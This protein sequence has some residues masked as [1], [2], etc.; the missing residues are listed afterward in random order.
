MMGHGCFSSTTIRV[1]FLYK[2]DA[3]PI[4]KADL[5]DE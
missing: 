1:K 2:Y 3:I 4:I 5:N